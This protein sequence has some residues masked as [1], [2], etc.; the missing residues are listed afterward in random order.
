MNI[1]K[2]YTDLHADYADVIY[3]AME[4]AV[5]DGTPVNAPL[6]WIDPTDHEALEIW[7]GKEHSW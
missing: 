6:W 7:D 3:Q 5:A 4:K 2:K 1:S